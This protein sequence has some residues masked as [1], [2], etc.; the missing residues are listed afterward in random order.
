MSA[1]SVL[2]NDPLATLEEVSQ[3]LEIEQPDHLDITL[4]D[5]ISFKSAN[6]GKWPLWTDLDI[7][8][9]KQGN[10]S[11]RG[12]AIKAVHDLCS[13]LDQ[14]LDRPAYQ[15]SLGSEAVAHHRERVATIRKKLVLFE[16]L[17]SPTDPKPLLSALEETDKRLG[18]LDL[19][20]PEIDILDAFVFQSGKPG[21]FTTWAD[22]DMSSNKAGTPSNRRE[23]ISA[24][25]D[26]VSK[27]EQMLARPACQREL[28]STELGR[29]RTMMIEVNK[30]LALLS[31]T[32]SPP[33]P[34]PLLSTLEEVSRRF[35]G[36]GTDTPDQS[37]LDSFLFR[38]GKPGLFTVWTDLDLDSDKAGSS[39]NRGAVIMAIDDLLAKFD[40]VL[41]RPACQKALGPSMQKYCSMRTTVGE[42]LDLFKN[43]TRQNPSIAQKAAPAPIVTSPTTPSPATQ[44]SSEQERIAAVKLAIGDQIPIRKP[45]LF[46][47]GAWAEAG[48]VAGSS[49][50]VT[51]L[52][53]IFVR[54]FA[55]AIP[56]VGLMAI[57]V[58]FVRRQHRVAIATKR[59]VTAKEF[60]KTATTNDDIVKIFPYLKEGAQA[61]FLV[62]L[63]PEFRGGVVKR[64]PSLETLISHIDTFLLSSPESLDRTNALT[65]IPKDALGEAV[66]GALRKTQGCVAG[67]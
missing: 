51:A 18:Q 9:N 59:C 13:K 7:R 25:R 58:S 20:A 39:N 12:E 23:V 2:E 10:A 62:D 65:N 67:F 8:S 56:L 35:E 36:V 37:I 48:A 4:L 46:S 31:D 64:Y 27:A 1:P 3:R 53:S 49:M 54:F 30:K 14:M 29:Y 33:N 47:R 61:Q 42:K 63:G 52:I 40:R 21:L 6:P 16:D 26:L 32:L 44:R 41:A 5:R 55:K 57:V 66:V 60:Y 28:G 24:L 11:N 34:Q 50:L 45:T 19:N 38:P 17:L 22:L 15:K 43:P